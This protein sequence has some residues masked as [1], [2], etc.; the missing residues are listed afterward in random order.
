MLGYGELSGRTCYSA[1]LGSGEE[2]SQSRLAESNVSCDKFPANRPVPTCRV[3]FGIRRET[4]WTFWMSRSIS[5]PEEVRRT[6]DYTLSTFRWYKV[7]VCLA[8][9]R[10]SI[11]S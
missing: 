9:G 8:G 6:L 5:G 3:R 11:F 7:L 2:S 10:L 1:R 4:H